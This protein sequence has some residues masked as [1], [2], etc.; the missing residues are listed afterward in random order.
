MPKCDLNKVSQQLFTKQTLILF[1]ARCWNDPPSL[2]SDDEFKERSR[3]Y[4][5]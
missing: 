4:R 2:L 3:S 5:C 1:L